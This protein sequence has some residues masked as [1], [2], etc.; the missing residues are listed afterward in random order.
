M[1][2]RSRSPV[3]GIEEYVEG[4]RCVRPRV[5]LRA[6]IDPRKTGFTIISSTDS[7]RSRFSECCLPDIPEYLFLCLDGKFV[8]D[9]PLTGWLFC[10]RR[11]VAHGKS[12]LRARNRVS[13]TSLPSG[14]IRLCNPL[15][16]QSP[17]CPQIPLADRPKQLITPAV[18]TT[19]RARRSLEAHPC[20]EQLTLTAVLDCSGRVF[21]S[22][23]PRSVIDL[24]PKSYEHSSL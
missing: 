5:H 2:S 6:E 13:R 16:S 4:E 24:S 7:V 11:H 9:L 21:V 20:D 3:I 19:P 10:W 1:R 14:T 8:V 22:E 12:S 23:D 18:C 17:H 15:R